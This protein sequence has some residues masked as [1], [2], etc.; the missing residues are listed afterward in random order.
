MSTTSNSTVVIISHEQRADG[1][2]YAVNGEYVH[3]SKVDHFAL[4]MY[5]KKMYFDACTSHEYSDIKPWD[6]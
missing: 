2:F 4:A 5:W 6:E 3:E 1:T